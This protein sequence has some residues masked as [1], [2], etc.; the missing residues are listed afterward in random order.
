MAIIRSR[1]VG[2]GFP[3]LILLRVLAIDKIMS[4][5]NLVKGEE[6]MLEFNSAIWDVAWCRND[7]VLAASW[8]GELVLRFYVPAAVL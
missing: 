4:R 7:V 3:F 5:C 8:R 1:G 6:M 2:A